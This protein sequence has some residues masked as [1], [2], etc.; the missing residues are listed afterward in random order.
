[1]RN[2]STLFVFRAIPPARL[3]VRCSPAY[4][5]R[6]RLNYNSLSAFTSQS[7]GCKEMSDG[8]GFQEARCNF[9]SWYYRY[10]TTS[11]EAPN[12]LQKS[13]P[14]KGQGSW[15]VQDHP[16]VVNSPNIICAGFPAKAPSA[17]SHS[18]CAPPPRVESTPRDR[19][20]DLEDDAG[21]FA[22]RRT[23]DAPLGA[24]PTSGGKQLHPRL[25]I[26]RVPECPMQVA[27]GS[28]MN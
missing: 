3:A 9:D 2:R 19:E 8:P 10:N 27:A 20:A 11:S 12:C 4:Q 6:I 17:D 26:S 15:P 18:T 5:Y 24:V 21:R 16:I 1:M 13:R 22:R 25:Q 14:M 23:P 28:N 7:L